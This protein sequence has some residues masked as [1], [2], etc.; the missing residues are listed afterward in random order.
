MSDVIPIAAVPNQTIAV[1]VAGQNC[2]VSIYQKTTGLYMDV[3]VD[4]EPIILSVICEDRNRIVRDA[5]LGF[6][7]DFAFYDTQGVT[8]PVYTGFG[9]RYLLLYISADEL[10]ALGIS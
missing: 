2:Q 9:S 10:A 5:Y 1:P 3:L 6:I 4:N 8:D 7:G